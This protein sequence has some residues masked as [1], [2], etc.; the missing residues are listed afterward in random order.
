MRFWPTS[1]HR[2][3]RPIEHESGRDPRPQFFS[4]PSTGDDEPVGATSYTEVTVRD[5]AESH[6]VKYS[7]QNA[8]SSSALRRFVDGL[9]DQFPPTAG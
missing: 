3:P 2:L 1:I 7:D 9:V 8:A 5:G 4:L 6:T